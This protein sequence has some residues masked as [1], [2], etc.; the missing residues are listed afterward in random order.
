[1][2]IKN[3]QFVPGTPEQTWRALND[4]DI[5]RAC[6]PGCE[7]VERTQDTE[8]AVVMR[9]K[10]GP[11][12]ARF[13]GK[14]Q[15]SNLNPPQ[16]Y[17][18]SFEGQGGAMG[19]GKGHAD[20]SLAAESGGTTLTYV[21]VAQV[22]GKLAQIG[23]RLIDG[24]ALKLADDFFA[25]F[26]EVTAAQSPATPVG[27]GPSAASGDAPRRASQAHWWWISALLIA[28]AAYFGLQS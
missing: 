4:P 26:I 23:S 5:L 24:A 1:M 22:G 7:S 16:S 12:S 14:M 20:V 9:A 15:L 2:E 17:T 11:V 28:A 27:A 19:F 8:M 3:S 6:I 10:V 25:R 21:V 13:R 18:V